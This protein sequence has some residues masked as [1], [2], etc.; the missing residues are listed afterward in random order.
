MTTAL[1]SDRQLERKGAAC[2]ADKTYIGQRQMKRPGA[3]VT[4][5]GDPSKLQENE[6]GATP[7]LR[8]DEG[9]ATPRIRATRL[10]KKAKRSEIETAERIASVYRRLL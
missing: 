2:G 9:A 3:E 7:R 4:I 8:E 1:Q 6:K 10:R 5:G